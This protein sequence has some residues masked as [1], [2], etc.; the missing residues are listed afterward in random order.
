MWYLTSTGVTKSD[1]Y[2]S[3][4]PEVLRQTFGCGFP[5]GYDGFTYS[6]SRNIHP[7]AWSDEWQAFQPKNLR[8]E[9]WLYYEDVCTLYTFSSLVPSMMDLLQ[10][11]DG[12]ICCYIHTYSFVYIT[13]CSAAHQPMCVVY[14]K[15]YTNVRTY[16]LCDA[17]SVMLAAYETAGFPGIGDL[18]L[19]VLI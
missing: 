4:E 11:T 14:L 15:E 12:V 13:L 17:C 3:T 7:A 19:I 18:C 16:V 10:H 5:N 9:I 8:W 2:G 1:L 6:Y